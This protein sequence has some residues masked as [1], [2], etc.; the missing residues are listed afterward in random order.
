LPVLVTRDDETGY[1][2]IQMADPR[3]CMGLSPNTFAPAHDLSLVGHDVK[4]GDEVSVPIRLYY[5]KI[6]SM[7]EVEDLYNQFRKDLG[8]PEE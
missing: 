8:I 5:R 3:E 4:S 1:A 2:L 6:D 7:T